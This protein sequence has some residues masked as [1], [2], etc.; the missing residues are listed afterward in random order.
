VVKPLPGTGLLLTGSGVYWILSSQLI[1]SFTVLM[2]E[3]LRGTSTGTALV[4]VAGVFASVVGF[5]MINFDFDELSGLVYKREGWVFVTPLILASLDIYVTIIGL[6]YGTGL[7]ELNPLVSAAIGSWP[8]ILTPFIIAYMALSQ[9]V[10]LLAIA[11]GRFL[12][13][14][15]PLRFLPF[16]VVCGAASFGPLSNLFL[17]TGAGAVWSASLAGTAGALVIGSIVYR[18]LRLSSAL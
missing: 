1:A 15:R 10:A 16:S 12:Y 3:L 7:V 9:G 17:L 8:S 4:L 2:P 11:I 14:T 13:G 6:T 18:S 5:W